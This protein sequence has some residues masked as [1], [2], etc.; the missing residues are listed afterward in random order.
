VDKLLPKKPK[1]RRI[2]SIDDFARQ[3]KEG[4]VDP[5]ELT[6][7]LERSVKAVENLPINKRRLRAAQFPAHKVM[8]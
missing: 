4:Q 1:T 2:M 6:N 5:T 7:F 8:A 3:A